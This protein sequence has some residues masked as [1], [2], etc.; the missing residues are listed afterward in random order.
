[1]DRSSTIFTRWL[2]WICNVAVSRQEEIRS[3]STK[4]WRTS[5]ADHI[6]RD[7]LLVG[8][9]F[10]LI[11]IDVYDTVLFTNVMMRTNGF[12]EIHSHVLDE[13]DTTDGNATTDGDA[14]INED[15]MKNNWE[16]LI[17]HECSSYRLFHS[18]ETSHSICPLI[19]DGELTSIPLYTPHATKMKHVVN[20]M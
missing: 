8:A 9:H 4:E 13:M 6:T 2:L 15:D 3:L 18:T 20:L 1:M 14:E 5:A 17:L 19:Y 12:S 16:M 10:F 7:N 11:Y